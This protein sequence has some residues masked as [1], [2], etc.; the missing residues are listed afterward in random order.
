GAD[1]CASRGDL[2]TAL[3]AASQSGHLELVR[4]L[5]NKLG[6]DVHEVSKLK[7][8]DQWTPLHY[9]A[10]FGNHDVAALLLD[11]NA[12]VDKHDAVGMAPLHY[13]ASHGQTSTV[14]LL[15]SRGADVNGVAAKDG[16]CALHYAADNGH[17]DVIKVLVS[18]GADVDNRAADWQTPLHCAAKMVHPEAI[19]LL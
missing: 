19:R 10:C 5:I 15:L 6:A 16:W 4:L 1:S 8:R 17:L 13:A 18:A 14:E 9:A 12:L 3:L 7:G 2:S 11:H